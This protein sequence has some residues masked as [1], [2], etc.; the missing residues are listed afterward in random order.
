MNSSGHLNDCRSERSLQNPVR[1]RMFCLSTGVVSAKCLRRKIIPAPVFFSRFSQAKS[2]TLSHTAFWAGLCEIHGLTL[3]QIIPLGQGSAL[4]PTE[5]C[6]WFRNVGTSVM[7][8]S[9][10][11]S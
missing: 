7:E 5:S 4:G 2:F 9:R 11:Q 6:E 10:A 8:R 1:W 3:C